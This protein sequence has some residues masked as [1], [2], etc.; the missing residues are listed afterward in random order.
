[1]HHNSEPLLCLITL[2]RSLFA[3]QDCYYLIAASG[4]SLEHWACCQS[5]RQPRLSPAMLSVLQNTRRF[6]MRTFLRDIDA[7]HASVHEARRVFNET[8]CFYLAWL[9]YGHLKTTS[10]PV[11]QIFC[12]LHSPI[13]ARFHKNI[14][15]LFLSGIYLLRSV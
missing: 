1:M 6:P 14:R 2:T 12:H 9:I 5:F 4:L 7:S 8:L 15:Q 10:H 11:L 3:T 13:F